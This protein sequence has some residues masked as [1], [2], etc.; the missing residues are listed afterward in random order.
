MPDDVG[1]GN[2]GG[3]SGTF[4]FLTRKVGP[5][6]IWAWGAI[7]V[8]IY[9]W[10]THYGPGATSTATTPV[11]TEKVVSSGGPTVT[12]THISHERP[13]HKRKPVNPGG[14]EK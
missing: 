8:G 5:L 13:H 9:Y 2:G 6:P 12:T 3:D 4:G 1:N 11:T 10:Y 14:P 7:A